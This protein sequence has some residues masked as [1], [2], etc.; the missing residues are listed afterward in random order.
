MLTLI[1]QQFPET[2]FY[3]WTPSDLAAVPV[4]RTDP[5]D[6]W[7]WTFLPLYRTSMLLV[8][9]D[10]GGALPRIGDWLVEVRVITDTGWEMQDRRIEPDASKFL[11]VEDADSKL[12]LMVFKCVGTVPQRQNWF[13]HVWGNASW[14]ED[15]EDADED[16]LISMKEGILSACQIDVPLQQMTSKEAV[17]AFCERAKQLISRKLDIDFA[18]S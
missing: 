7:G 11:S 5:R 9:R 14:P 12:S 17:K 15:L 6:F 2:D 13:H 10:G 3:N 18:A 1:G 8:P 4:S 16:G